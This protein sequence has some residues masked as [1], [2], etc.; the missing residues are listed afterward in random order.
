[1]LQCLARIAALLSLDRQSSGLRCCTFR[2]WLKTRTSDCVEN[3]YV[4]SQ[5][6]FLF[7]IDPTTY[8]LHPEFPHF[9][10]GIE[11]EGN[12]P[13]TAVKRGVKGSQK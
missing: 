10:H 13:A 1:M 5:L 6:H 4:D 7:P 3:F 11:V 2:D 9:P 8:Y 12:T